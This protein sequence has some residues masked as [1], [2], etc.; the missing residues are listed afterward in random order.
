MSGLYCN[1]K[2]ILRYKYEQDFLLPKTM[3]LLLQQTYLT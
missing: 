3:G 2:S 1:K